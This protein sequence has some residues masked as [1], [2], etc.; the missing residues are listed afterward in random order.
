[1]RLPT[2]EMR[3]F[4]IQQDHPLA[5]VGQLVC[6]HQPGQSGADHDDIGAVVF[7]RGGHGAPPRFAVPFCPSLGA[8]GRAAQSL[9]V[10]LP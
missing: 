2:E 5:T 4:L 10:A 3:R 6:R 7:L 9:R 1:M 8:R